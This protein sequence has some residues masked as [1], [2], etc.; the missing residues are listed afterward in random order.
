MRRTLA[1][2]WRTGFATGAGIATGDAAYAAIAGLGLASVQHV[3]LAHGRALHLVAGLV[4][5]YLGVRTMLAAGRGTERGG[6]GVASAPA[7][8]GS[9][10]LLT[11][12]NPPTIVLF[13][14]AFVVLAPAGALAPTAALATIGGVFAGSL[15]W[16]L[17]LTAAIAAV[18][19][20]LPLGARVWIDWIQG[21]S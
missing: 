17:G 2:G 12:T 14:A 5:L 13:A 4:L 3:L 21:A 16:W 11:L 1:Q 19:G 15:L 20:T 9:A 10:V 6:A 18:R 8:Y 7:A